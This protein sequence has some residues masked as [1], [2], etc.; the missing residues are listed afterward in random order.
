[1]AA[2]TAFLVAVEAVIQTSGG[3]PTEI[4]HVFCA[5][6]LKWLDDLALAA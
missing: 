4:S 5:S 1:M 3:A 2:F 6:G